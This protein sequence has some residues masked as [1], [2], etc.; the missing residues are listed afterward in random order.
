MSMTTVHD[1]THASAAGVPL[2]STLPGRSRR[3]HVHWNQVAVHTILIIVALAAL[4]PMIWCV[5]A[6]FKHFRELVSSTDLFPHV[7][8]LDSYKVV[9]GLTYLWTGFRNTIIVTFS[10]T[11]VAVFTSTLEGY[12]FAKFDFPFKGVL[13]VALLATMMV[14]F[15]VVLIPLFLILKDFGL[16]NQL[17]G[18]IVTGLFSTF[19]IFMLRQF[20]FNIPSELLDSGRI[21]GASEWRIFFELIIPL[22]LSPM[23]ALGIFIFLGAWNDF[24]WPS[25]VL[26]NSD[27]QTLPVVINGLQGLFWTQYDYLITAAV[28]SVV[29]LM[30]CY[31]FGSRYMIEGV[32]MTGM[33][34]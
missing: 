26:T 30:I 25:V 34:L 13:F 5:F 2:S 3:V 24:L 7:W 21:D 33:K 9:F 15:I 27:R 12:V 16:V 11:A 8:T 29:P 32:A 4:L 18:I 20:M 1:D 10:I 19:G 6:S 31:L 17:A 22:S 28:V 14:P 23:S